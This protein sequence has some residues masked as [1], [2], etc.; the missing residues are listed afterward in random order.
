MLLRLSHLAFLFVALPLACT[1]SVV[2]DDEGAAG[3]GGSVD[4]D[5]GPQPAQTSLP[6]QQTWTC[7]NGDWIST[8]SNCQTPCPPSVPE[9]D[10][11][12]GEVGKECSYEDVYTCGPIET[13]T[14][15]CTEDGWDVTIPYCLPEPECPDAL[16][17]DGGSCE[18]W[19]NAFG[20]SYDVEASCGPVIATAFCEYVGDEMIWSAQLADE[21]PT[22]DEL[23]TPET[24]GAHSGCAW[25]GE[26]EVC[27]AIEA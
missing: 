12:C 5:C 3:S 18:G 6:C 10:A 15:N 26:T 14:A 16:P 2:T 24:C 1:S 27:E 21:C 19:D 20:C 13:I 7:S 8:V 23:T 4:D 9:H 17:L 11:P 22:C 25:Q